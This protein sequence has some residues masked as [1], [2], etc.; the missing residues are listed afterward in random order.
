MAIAAF[1][2]T[3]DSVEGGRK[4]GEDIRP[5]VHEDGTKATLHRAAALTTTLRDVF[6]SPYQ[7]TV[8]CDDSNSVLT[9][10]LTCGSAVTLTKKRGKM[11][12]RT[13]PRCTRSVQTRLK[14]INPLHTVV[15]IT[16]F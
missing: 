8:L 9:V 3:V 13:A 5:K 1:Y 6:L 15:L 11:A 4:V 7:R 12:C 16:A 10:S 14:G 2:F